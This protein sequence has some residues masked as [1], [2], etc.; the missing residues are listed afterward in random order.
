MFHLSEC[1][2][3]FGNYWI[4]TGINMLLL[5]LLIFEVF[6]MLENNLPFQHI[7]KMTLKGMVIVQLICLIW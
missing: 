5:L 2:V 6:S 4:I 3:Y 7:A 1:Y